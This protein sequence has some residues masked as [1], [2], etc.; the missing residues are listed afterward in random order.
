M[1]RQRHQAA[2]GQDLARAQHGPF[3]FKSRRSTAVVSRWLIVARRRIGQSR[4]GSKQR[5]PE[6][7][8]RRPT[9]RQAPVASGHD[10]ITP[11]I[12]CHTCSARN[13]CDVGRPLA[14]HAV[15]SCPTVTHQSARSRVRGCL[16]R[17]VGKQLCQRKRWPCHRLGRAFVVVCRNNTQRRA[18]PR[19]VRLVLP[20]VLGPAWASWAADSL[21]SPEK[22]A[23]TL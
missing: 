10:R 12:E 22:K 9:G 15:R 2:D 23:A 19:R 7:A 5:G 6:R 11:G 4:I 3:P 8:S 18:S 13:M 16:P 17:G 20:L 14:P 1:G 21:R